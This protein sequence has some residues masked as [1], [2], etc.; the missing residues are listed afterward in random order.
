MSY[1]DEK[2]PEITPPVMLLSPADIYAI[3][4][5]INTTPPQSYHRVFGLED[6]ASVEDIA[7]A[8]KNLTVML[9]VTSDHVSGEYKKTIEDAQKCE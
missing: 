5:Y 9:D 3:A 8:I 1:T 7:V 6:N 2:R 4:L